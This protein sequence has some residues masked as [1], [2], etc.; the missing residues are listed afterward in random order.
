MG[1]L[2]LNQYIP[3]STWTMNSDSSQWWIFTF[4]I[5]QDQPYILGSG[6]FNRWGGPYAGGGLF[7]MADGSVHMA[8]Y[9]TPNTIIIAFC[10]PQGGEAYTPPW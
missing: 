3:G 8:S 2:P 6:T 9:S 4:Q 10:T 1:V 7:A 5:L